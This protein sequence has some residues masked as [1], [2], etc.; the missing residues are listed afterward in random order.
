MKQLKEVQ[1]KEF[2]TFGTA[3]LTELTMYDGNHHGFVLYSNE[4]EAPAALHAV[5][6]KYK[7]R[8]WVYG[9]SLRR[10]EWEDHLAECNLLRWDVQSK[11]PK[12]P[13]QDLE[14]FLKSGSINPPDLLGPVEPASALA[15][16]LEIV[17]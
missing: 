14:K 4:E 7:A 1:Q 13:I 9:K 6:S 16:L 3:T 8:D 15:D 5:R 10:E 12:D 11:T 17:L 2:N